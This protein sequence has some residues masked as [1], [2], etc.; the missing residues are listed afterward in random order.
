MT[1]AQPSP[2][3]MQDVMKQWQD[4]FGSIGAQN[5]IASMGNRLGSEG[6]T[7]KPNNL[8]TDGPY[9][10]IKEFISGYIIVK[11]ENIDEAVELAKSCPI[12]YI[13]G[14]VEVRKVV[15]MNDNS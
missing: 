12:L 2:Q 10:E 4:W 11:T 13:G 3:Q 1:G 15:G 8:V 5:K 14:N 7:V 9:V 6:K